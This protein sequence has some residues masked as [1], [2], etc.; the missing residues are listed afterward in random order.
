[1]DAT[2]TYDDDIVTWAEQQAAALRDLAARPELSNVVDWNNVIEE[3]ECLGRSEWKAVVS[4]L[5][6]ALAHVLKGYCDPD[7]LSRLGWSVETSNSLREARQDFRNSMRQNIDM[8]SVWKNAFR[9]ASDALLP[10]AVII[11]P[12][13]PA[14]CP[15]TLDEVLDEAFTYDSAVQRLYELLTDWRLRAGE[16]RKK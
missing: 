4:Q 15:F 16:D 14:P 12:A 10:Y 1:M 5:R 3:I 7:S 6:N 9:Q 8:D 11:P 2:T 13:I